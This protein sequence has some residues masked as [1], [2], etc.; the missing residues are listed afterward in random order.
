[1][2]RKASGISLAALLCVVI[3]CSAPAQDALDVRSVETIRAAYIH[4]IG[5]VHTKL[6]A[7]AR[8]IPP[9]KYSWRPA[10]GVRSVSEVLM[11]VAGEFYDFAPLAVGGRPPAAYSGEGKTEALERI[12][13]KDAVIAEFEKAWA[14]TKLELPAADASRLTGKKTFNRDFAAAVLLVE[15]DQHEH[16]GQLIA[17]ARSLGVKPPWTR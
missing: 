15:G 14:H 5:D 6:L 10:T 4:D 11:H 2:S 7:L 1:M 3:A 16:L 9:D 12:T 17:Y 13:S 8:A